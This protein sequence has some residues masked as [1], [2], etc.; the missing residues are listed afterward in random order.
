VLGLFTF[1]YQWNEFLWPLIATSSTE[2]R[3][4]TVG[5]TL[6]NQEF[7]TQWNLTAA[8]A[9]ILFI[10]TLVLFFVAQ[11]FLVRGI[12]LTGLK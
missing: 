4:M 6:F 9:V 2:M 12:A 1:V 10:P 11:R 7:F 3:T 5:L 8:G